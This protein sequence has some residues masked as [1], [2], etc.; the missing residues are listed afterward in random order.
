MKDNPFLV[1]HLPAYVLFEDALDG[2][3]VLVAV[4][5]PPLTIGI[6]FHSSHIHLIH[7]VLQQGRS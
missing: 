2:S 1:G 5:P 4:H 3:P 6:Q 7:S